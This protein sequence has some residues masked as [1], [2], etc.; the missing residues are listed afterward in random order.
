MEGVITAVE[1]LGFP[2]AIA[3]IAIIGVYKTVT[4][5]QDE[6]KEREEKLISANEKNSEA[7]K[8]VADTIEKGNTVNYN[9]AETNRMLVDKIETKLDNIDVNIATIKEKVSEK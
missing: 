1:T 8:S 3:I 4:R 2:I 5:T 6:A 7:L 9:L